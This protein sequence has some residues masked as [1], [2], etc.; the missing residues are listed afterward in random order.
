MCLYVLVGGSSS[1]KC[2]GPLGFS[3]MGYYPVHDA[4]T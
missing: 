1:F 3:P 2:I 4:K